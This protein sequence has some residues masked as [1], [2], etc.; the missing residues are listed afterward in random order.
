MHMKHLLVCIL[1]IITLFVNVLLTFGLQQHFNL[2]RII[3]I[4]VIYVHRY[5]VINTP[6]FSTFV[7]FS[8]L[9][10]VTIWA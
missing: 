5:I 9:L 1:K 8:N 3:L 4:F 2:N 10:I 7:Y 6:F